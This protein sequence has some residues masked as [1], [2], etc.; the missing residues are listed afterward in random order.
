M[1]DKNGKPVREGDIVKVLHIDSSIIENLPEEEKDAV[2]SMLHAVLRVYEVDEYGQVWVE[3][4]WERGPGMSESHSLGL[5][6]EEI[7]LSEDV[8]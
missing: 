6:S 8:S 1:K 2:A 7:E 3:K 5:S 4:E